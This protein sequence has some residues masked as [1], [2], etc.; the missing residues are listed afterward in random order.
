M[1]IFNFIKNNKKVIKTSFFSLFSRIIIILMSFTLTILLARF[2]GPEEFGK[3]SYYMA[4]Y[5]IFMMISTLGLNEIIV[6]KFIKTKNLEFIKQTFIIRTLIV[7]LLL[8]ISNFFIINN[9]G[10][11]NEKIFASLIIGSLIFY[12]VSSL[13]LYMQ[14]NSYIRQIIFSELISSLIG[15]LI[16]IFILFMGKNIIYISVVIFIENFLWATLRII[17]FNKKYKLKSKKIK[18]IIK[19]STIKKSFY[20]INESWQILLS[21]FL[22]TIYMKVDLIII[23]LLMG[24]YSVGIY[25]VAAKFS[26]AWSFI[27]NTLML[28]FF[29]ILANSVNR[30]IRKYNKVYKKVTFIFSIISLL[31]I[32]FTI[33]FGDKIVNILYGNEYSESV[34]ILKIHIFSIFFIF[35]GL[36]FNRHLILKNKK[37]EILFATLIGAVFNIVLNFILIP[38]IGLAGPALASVASYAI[39]GFL[40]YSLIPNTKEDFNLQNKSI[41]NFKK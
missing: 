28:I 15:F 2:Y 8:L 22:I 25:S 14:S 32:I 6:N 24:E 13:D 31:I 41:W 12:P 3:Y 27:S 33:L 9:I 16:K 7:S 19:I 26:E 30:N 23:K 10:T 1:K 34:A 37:K 4:L 38:I 5:S 39:S 21:S 20:L 11:K 36:L 35:I 18:N 17:L 29:P 40:I